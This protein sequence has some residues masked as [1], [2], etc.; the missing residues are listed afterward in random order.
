M[1]SAPGNDH[2]RAEQTDAKP[3][4]RKNSR[5][6]V[7]ISG[8]VEAVADTTHGLDRRP[9]QALSEPTYADVDHIAAG[10]VVQPP[11]VMVQLITAAHA[12]APAHQVREQR[13]L[14]FAEP[15]LDAPD[16]RPPTL[17]VDP[18][19]APLQ[20]AAPVDLAHRRHGQVP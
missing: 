5:V 10:V 7:R 8:P 1:V 16:G 13:E 20:Y 12:A 6:L 3:T 9:R 4:Q 11:D 14:P 19:A 17:E 15:L 2:M 18:D